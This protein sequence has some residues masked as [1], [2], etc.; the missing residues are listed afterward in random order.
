MLRWIKSKTIWIVGGLLAFILALYGVFRIAHARS[1]GKIKRK[2]G[3]A[4]ARI[5]VKKKTVEIEK[6]CARE[7]EKIRHESNGDLLERMDGY[8]DEFLR[9]EKK[10]DLD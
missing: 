5:R 3:D 6:D 4:L 8:D 7:Q 9:L 1:L 10:Y 2:A